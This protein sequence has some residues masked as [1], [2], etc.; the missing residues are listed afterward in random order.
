MTNTY[1]HGEIYSSDLPFSAVHRNKG[2]PHK[3]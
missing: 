1:K 2:Q 3:M